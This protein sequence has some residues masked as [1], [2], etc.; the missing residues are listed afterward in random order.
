MIVGVKCENCGIWTRITGT[1]RMDL[2]YKV[3][4]SFEPYYCDECNNIHLVTMTPNGP[5][6]DDFGESGL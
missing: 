3:I 1:G 2:A 6:I 4:S 5:G